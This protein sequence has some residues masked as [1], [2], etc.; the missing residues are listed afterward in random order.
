[1]DR[2]L[3]VLVILSIAGITATMLAASPEKY[4]VASLYCYGILRNIMC[5]TKGEHT[6]N[7]ATKSSTITQSSWSS[8]YFRS[9]KDLSAVTESI[10]ARYL[11]TK[12]N[13]SYVE[14]HRVTTSCGISLTA[15]LCCWQ[16]CFQAG[17]AIVVDR[18]IANASLR[19]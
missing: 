5:Q 18:T 3:R 11:S 10:A 13:M 1:M 19:N 7:M 2:V 4:S 16:L 14:F 17:R 12:C 8:S 6:F 9:F 15:S